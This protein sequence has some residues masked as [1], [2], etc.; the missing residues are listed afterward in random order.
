[1]RDID[2]PQLSF[3]D[4]QILKHK[5]GRELAAIATLLE[6]DHEIALLVHRDLTSAA[7]AAV[8]RKGLTAMQVLRCAVLKQWGRLTYD[9]L[10]FHLRDSASFRQ[11]ARILGRGPSRSALQEAIISITAETWERINRALLGQAQDLGIETGHMTRLDSTAIETF[12]HHPT[13]ATLLQDCVRVITRLLGQGLERKPRPRY[14]FANHNRVTKR[15]VLTIN[16]AKSEAIREAAYKKLISIATRVRMSGNDGVAGLK[17]WLQEGRGSEEDQRWAEKICKELERVIA[18]LEKI[19]DQTKRRVLKK[20]KVETSEKIVSIFETHTDIIVKGQRETVFGHKMFVVSGKSSMILDCML[21]RGNPADVEYFVPI[22]MRQAEIMG[23]IPRQ[24]A[25]DG[26]FASRSNLH[27]GKRL[28]V[29]DVVFA[30]RRGLAVEDMAGSKWIFNKLRDFRAGIEGNI[31][32]LKRA[33]GLNCSMWRGWEGFL[34]Y[35]WSSIVSYN[36]RVMARQMAALA[37]G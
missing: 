10:E 17:L 12:I 35:V 19:I 21:P 7:I 18:L 27:E 34:R 30:K 4:P 9:E 1:M 25:A 32:T 5:V 13:D 28:G 29:K 36:L 14:R 23:K 11:F 16:D 22:V 8:G 31:S 3:K 6:T 26:G 20:E 37:A 33:F 2:N 15:L 24:T